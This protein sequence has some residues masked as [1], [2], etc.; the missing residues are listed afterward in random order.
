MRSNTQK[1]VLLKLL[2]SSEPAI[3][4]IGTIHFKTFQKRADYALTPFAFPALVREDGGLPRAM[5]RNR[6]AFQPVLPGTPGSP[7]DFWCN[8]VCSKYL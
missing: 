1:E 2:I 4:A 6:L 5:S 3:G 8:P 7:E